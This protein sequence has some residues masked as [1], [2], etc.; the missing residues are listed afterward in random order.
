MRLVSKLAKSPVWLG[1]GVFGV[2]FLSTFLL[3]AGL[4]QPTF[5]TRL[6]IAP[7]STKETLELP[8]VAAS[9]AA[10]RSQYLRSVK[11]TD[12]IAL[13]LGKGLSQAT[14]AAALTVRG[15]SFPGV[16]VIEVRGADPEQVAAIA[17]A[18][19]A[20]SL[21]VEAPPGA[22]QETGSAQTANPSADH[23][24]DLLRL[25][26]AVAGYKADLARHRTQ[27]S[28]I[29]AS[30]NLTSSS[31]TTLLAIEAA[32]ASAETA[33][34]KLLELTGTV[35]TQPEKLRA[36]GF[37][38][39]AA[40]LDSK[41][42]KPGDG[43]AAKAYDALLSSTVSATYARYSQTKGRLEPVKQSALAT[44]RLKDLRAQEVNVQARLAEA[45]IELASATGGNAA[46][47]EDRTAGAEHQKPLSM[48]VAMRNAPP[49]TSSAGRVL[50]EPYRPMREG[51]LSG[52]ASIAAALVAAALATWSAL[53]RQRSL[54]IERGDT[55]TIDAV[56][57]IE[58]T[59]KLGAIPAGDL[60]RLPPSLRNL[61]GYIVRNPASGHALEF[62]KLRSAVWAS[63]N[64]RAT[65]K[66]T[67]VVTDGPRGDT[68]GLALGLAR[69]AA[70]AGRRA[71]L[72][73]CRLP[74]GALEA[75]LLEERR[76]QGLANLLSGEAEWKDV[77][78]VDM[79]SGTH[80][81]WSGDF[82]GL[83]GPL[84]AD[85]L[86]ETMRVISEV[87]DCIVLDLGNVDRLDDWKPVLETCALVLLASDANAFE[88]GRTKRALQV[89]RTA[90][91]AACRLFLMQ[92]SQQEPVLK[93]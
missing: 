67:A 38:E 52:V 83:A 25:E 8:D 73:D 44:R 93:L 21:E 54:N 34:L 15:S 1:T 53:R 68:T 20:V 56:L 70:V 47:H 90:G 9:F 46:K 33:Y 55:A 12:A 62:R 64:A 77:V 91:G 65:R 79:E 48:P 6:S 29:L 61:A 14:V 87:Y 41:L 63:S 36:A 86:L 22:P 31:E 60:I 76:V 78:T 37:S 23:P 88:V 75:Y 13:R 57:G 82:S 26:R 66:I 19:R 69:I 92:P 89:I 30:A 16:V 51:L 3:T 11:A 59:R 2:V 17:A 18:A 40:A 84:V 72:I 50:L 81:L 39:L 27:I 49:S 74:G 5:V 80:L 28:S 32:A 42:A 4:F 24:V 85:T 35:V 45:E 71:L 43:Q 10:V 7:S 58:G